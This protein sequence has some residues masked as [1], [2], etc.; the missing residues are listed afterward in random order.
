MGDEP[1]IERASRPLKPV[2]LTAAAEPVSWAEASRI[3]GLPGPGSGATL[4]VH[5]LSPG[6]WGAATWRCGH[7]V[8]GW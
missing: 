8:H 7:G 1:P 4:Q 3:N 5:V 2:N 6:F